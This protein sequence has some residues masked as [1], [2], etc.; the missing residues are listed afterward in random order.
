MKKTGKTLL[1]IL[2]TL[3]LSSCG[4]QA[5]QT[6]GVSFLD[7]CDIVATIEVINGDSVIV[8][9]YNKIRQRKNVPLEELLTD[10]TILKLDNEN[11]EGLIGSKL[12]GHI[13]GEKYIAVFQYSRIPLKLFDKRGN[14][15]RTIGRYGQGPGEYGVIN[16]VWM[17][18]KFDRIY[19]LS[20]D[21]DKVLVYDFEGNIYPPIPMPERVKYGNTIIVD[22][23]KQ[24]LT[25][26]QSPWSGGIHSVWIQDFKGNVI[27]G[28]KQSD[29]FS[30]EISASNSSITQLFTDNL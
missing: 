3:L 17:D 1:L 15:I 18:E 26:T 27:Q 2:I 20:F 4:N 16:N 30:D 13:I 9:D 24:K 7:D 28:V 23:E 14:Y 8:C 10:F 11:D 22:S 5:R 29:C 19:V 25:V 6:G 21:T 12:V